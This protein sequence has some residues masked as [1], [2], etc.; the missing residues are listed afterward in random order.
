M[1]LAKHYKQ[2]TFALSFL[3]KKAKYSDFSADFRWK[4]YFSRLKRTAF[5]I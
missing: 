4:Y 5:L 3:Y 2:S 1:K